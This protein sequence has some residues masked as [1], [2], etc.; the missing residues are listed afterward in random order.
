M[1]THPL[2]EQLKELRC[3]GMLEALNEQ[4]QQQDIAQLS[5]DDRF[6][7]LVEREYLTRENRRL[8]LRLRQARFKYSNACLEDI[9]YS[10]ARGLSKAI[11]QQLAG[12]IWVHRKQ[13]IIITGST[14]TGK[15]YLACALANQAC[16]KGLNVRYLRIP[17]LLQ[18][19][20]IAKGDGS[21]AKLLMSLEK[22]H[23]LILDD[24]GVTTM[25]E[26]QRHDLLEIIDDRHNQSST[27]IT[28]Q[29]PVKM[30]HDA[31]GDATLGDAILDRVI[32]NAHRI[33]L[34][35][36]SLRKK[37]GTISEDNLDK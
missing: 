32:H 10:A 13:N 26:S 16:R 8:S 2:T 7:L 5:F 29:L 22:T 28:S 27:I 9:D 18:N 1:L 14:G 36:E 19:V 37:Y 11:I 33:C 24:W 15:T 3:H 35:G 30:W 25:T 6:A 31:I 4:I 23:I 21:Y 12:C 20:A 34:Q 17:R